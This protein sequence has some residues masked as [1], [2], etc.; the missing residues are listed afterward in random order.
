MEATYIMA[1]DYW[2]AVIVQFR[3]QEVLLSSAST[4]R[5]IF[6][7]LGAV[8]VGEDVEDDDVIWPRNPSMGVPTALRIRGYT[9]DP[10][11]VATYR[12]YLADLE[13]GS[14][15]RKRSPILR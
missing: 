9:R 10:D 14:F 5:S 15:D 1:D 11:V 12:Q 6:E 3:G 13:D 7:A 4:K 2:P 8:F